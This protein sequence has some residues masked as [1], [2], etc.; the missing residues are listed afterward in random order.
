M[1]EW[2]RGDGEM[3]RIRTGFGEGRSG[4]LQQVA[5]SARTSRSSSP[6]GGIIRHRRRCRCPPTSPVQEVTARLTRTFAQ[7]D[8]PG[9]PP[10]G[11]TGEPPPLDCSVRPDQHRAAAGELI[12]TLSRSGV[13]PEF[14]MLIGCVPASAAITELRMAV[15]AAC[16]SSL[17]RGSPLTQVAGVGGQVTMP[18]RWRCPRPS[19]RQSWPRG[20]RAG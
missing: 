5:L 13:S 6:A 19:N 10:V 9:V 17:M 15:T 8:G 16:R 2:A 18:I 3:T 4:K 7:M 1:R 20:S 14:V 11:P 12:C